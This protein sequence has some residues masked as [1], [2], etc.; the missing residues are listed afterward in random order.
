MK[1]ANDTF[2][3]KQTQNRVSLL[4]SLYLKFLLEKGTEKNNSMVEVQDGWK[5]F[6]FNNAKDFQ[7]T[8]PCYCSFAGEKI[9]EK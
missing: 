1:K 7:F 3:D 8:K 9:Y 5:L 4:L 6:D 2:L